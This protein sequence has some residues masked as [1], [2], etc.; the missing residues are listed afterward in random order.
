MTILLAVDTSGP[1]CSLAIHVSGR[2]IEDTQPVERLHN[3]VVLEHLESLARRAGVARRGFEVVA[4]AAGPGSFTG[5]R[6]AAAVAQGVAYACGARV[7]PVSSSLALAEAALVQLPAPATPGLVTVIRSRRDANYLAA[8][9]IDRGRVVECVHDDHLHQGADAPEA[10]PA[11]WTGVGERP[12][13]WPDDQP[14]RCDVAVTAM[15]VGR[16]ALDAVARGATLEPAAA[17]PRY[18]SGDS[19]WRPMTQPKPPAVS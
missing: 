15:T 11:T 17:L 3:R 4:F 12:A 10:L 13:W 6:I 8:Y 19:P 18:V 7:V 2:W 1:T 9:R 16:L 14:F 5:V